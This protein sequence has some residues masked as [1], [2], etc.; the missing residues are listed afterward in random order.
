MGTKDKIILHIKFQFECHRWCSNIYRKIGDIG[1]SKNL[2]KNKREEKK[3]DTITNF[4]GN[5]REKF[6]ISQ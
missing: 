3:S 4:W 5:I 2:K 6:Q 1:K